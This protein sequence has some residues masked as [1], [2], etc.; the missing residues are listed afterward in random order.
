MSSDFDL[1]ALLR[2]CGKLWLEWVV[3]TRG[4]PHSSDR[5]TT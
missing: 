4:F 2:L 5:E 3:Y 1:P